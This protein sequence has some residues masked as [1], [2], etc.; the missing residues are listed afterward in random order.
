MH[1]H[2]QKPIF[3]FRSKVSANR[4]QYKEKKHFFYLDCWG[5]A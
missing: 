2:T 1:I 3:Q 4:T 5:A